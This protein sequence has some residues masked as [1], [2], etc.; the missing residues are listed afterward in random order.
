MRLV[1][2]IPLIVK[3]RIELQH[4]G[5]EDRGG[6]LCV[7]RGYNALQRITCYERNEH[8]TNTTD[9]CLSA[10][11]ERPQ[12]ENLLVKEDI[13][14]YNLSGQFFTIE[15][16]GYFLESRVQYIIDWDPVSLSMPCKYGNDNWLPIHWSILKQ[17]I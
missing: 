17:D 3:L 2:F 14:L 12:E 10:V 9:D 16:S 5:A 13:K 4:Y 8:K 6:L 1:S 7:L 15:N 11:K